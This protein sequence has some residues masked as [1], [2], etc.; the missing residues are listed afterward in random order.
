MRIPL[1]IILIL[2]S[3]ASMSGQQGWTTPEPHA[4]EYSYSTKWEHNGLIVCQVP[5]STGKPELV[6]PHG[7]QECAEVMAD[8]T[9]QLLEQK[10]KDWKECDRK[11]LALLAEFKL[12][13]KQERA[14]LNDM[15]NAGQ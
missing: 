13:L 14:I 2:S 7:W 12:Y 15:K 11:Y 1:V 8:A 4:V 3:A 9:Q 5:K 10:T 6:W